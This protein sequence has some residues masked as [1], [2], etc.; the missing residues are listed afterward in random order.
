MN[1]LVNVK[2]S[3]QKDGL[4]RVTVSSP[5][6]NLR[7]ELDLPFKHL[8]EKCGIPDEIVLDLLFVASV[9]YVIDKAIPRSLASDWWTRELEVVMP[10]SASS[11]WTAVQSDLSEAL[12]F[13]TGDVWTLSFQDR[14]RALFKPPPM[15]RR[16][17]QS[18][19]RDDIEAVCLFSGGV[20]SL[21]APSICWRV[22]VF[23]A[24]G[25]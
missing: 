7:Y 22:Q 5:D 16:G 24:Y 13:L 23:A 8:Y 19:R 9:C 25:W 6:L 2:S 4:S 18:N 10:V 20:D 1:I 3:R 14:G 15:K 11:L 17:V 21:S 12:S